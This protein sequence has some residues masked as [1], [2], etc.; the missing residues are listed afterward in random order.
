M[1]ALICRRLLS[2]NFMEKLSN[3]A[4]WSLCQKYGGLA[5]AYRKKFV[6]L[7]PE[8]ERRK[9]YKKY[10]FHSVYEFAARVGGVS[11]R[12]VDEVLRTYEKVENKPLLKA[13]IEM[14]GYSKVRAVA[15]LPIEEN[16]LVEM[17]KTLP[18]TTLETY[19]RNIKAQDCQNSP[20]REF[21]TLRIDKQTEFRLKKYQQKLEK[22]LKVPVTLNQTL[23]ML[24][25]KVEDPIKEPQKRESHTRKP[26][27]Y[28]RFRNDNGGK[29]AFPNCNKPHEIFHH[30]NRY[31]L[32]P[33]HENITPLCEEHHHLAHGGLIANEHES[34][35][36]W[37]LRS[38]MKPNEIDKKYL[39][40][41]QMATSPQTPTLHPI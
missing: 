40:Y 26:S 11:V 2:K 24:L 36:K 9:L 20:G 33:S 31:A 13:Q 12:V 32:D 21:A 25:D 10:G 37:K 41:V 8:V 27:A 1:P 38:E 7:L 17:V 6:A 5:L 18:K 19:A 15:D 28:D 22:E 30:P 29:C 4:L 16:K 34:P 35:D 23:G 3:S 14:Q 39:K